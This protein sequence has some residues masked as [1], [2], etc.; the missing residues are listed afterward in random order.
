MGRFVVEVDHALEA[1]LLNRLD[2]GVGEVR[3]PSSNARIKD[4]LRERVGID[5]SLAGGMHTCFGFEE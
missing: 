1:D 2:I 4:I 5:M 3:L